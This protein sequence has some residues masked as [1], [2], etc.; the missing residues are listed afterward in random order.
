MC[1]IIIRSH[2]AKSP[3]DIVHNRGWKLKLNLDLIQKE[4]IKREIF[5]LNIFLIILEKIFLKLGAMKKAPNSQ[6]KPH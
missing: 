4:K 3:L 1:K 5:F 6:K 2:E